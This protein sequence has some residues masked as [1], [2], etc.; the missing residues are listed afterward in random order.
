[1]KKI[2]LALLLI[3][4]VFTLAAC[5]TEPETNEDLV[6]VEE[7]RDALLI[8]GLDRVT[9]DL[10]LPT[11]GR[12]ETTVTWSS[13][14]TDVIGNDGTVTRPAEGEDNATVT[15]TATVT[16]N[17][18]S[19][20]RSFEALVVAFEPSNLFTD[21]TELYDESAINDLVT[22]EGLVSTVFD[23][24]FFV[25]DGAEYV[26]V[27]MGSG[28][29]GGGV[30]EIGDEVAVT[31]LYARYYTLYQLSE[32]ENVEVLST[33]NTVD[34]TGDESTI[35]AVNALDSQ[36]PLIH[37]DFYELTGT[38]V[39][40]GEFNNLFL[41]SDE[42]DDEV[43]IY[44]YSDEDSLTALEE[45]LGRTITVSLAYYT[46]HASN[47]IMMSYYGDGSDV[48]VA[49]LSDAQKLALDIEVLEET[50]F[51][52][53]GDA[54]TLPTT[55]ANGTAYTNWE[56]EDLTLIASDGS[57]VAAPT[58]PTDV[59]FTATA[60]LGDETDTVE[61]TVSSLAVIS[62]EDALDV[63][64]GGY[65]MFTGKVVEVISGN[66][67]FYVYD[68]TGLIYVRDTDFYD[69]NKDDIEIGDSWTFVG[70]RTD[71][72]GL[73]QVASLSL[74]ETSTET[75]EDD[76][77][78]GFTTL[79]SIIAGDIVPGAKYTI[80]GTVEVVVGTYT[81]I[82]VVDGDAR[83]Q[84]HFN[85]N[86]SVIED[87]DGE[88]VVIEIRP[89]QFDY[90]PS[91]V[92]FIGTADDVQEGI[93][94]AQ[95]NELA[96]TA[97]DLGLVT[98]TENVTLPA[99]GKFDLALTWS[100]SNTDVFS[101]TGEVSKAATPQDIVLTLTVGT[102]TDAY[103][104]DYDLSVG[105]NVKDALALEDGVMVYV[106]GTVV[107]LD[108][109][110]DGFFMQDAS[111]GSAIYVGNFDEDIREDV[112]VGDL[113]WILGERDSYTSYGNAQQ[114][115]QN[116]EVLEVVSSDNDIYVFEDMT[117]DEI[118]SGFPGTE[119][120]RFVGVEVTVDSYDTYDHVFFETELGG[121]KLTLD[122]TEVTGWTAEA[123]PV[124]TVL[125]LDF[126]TQ[127]I[128]YNNYRVVDV[129]VNPAE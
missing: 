39:Q 19:A 30:V 13:S 126:T 6:L 33:G 8:S 50:I 89:F 95:K 70:A 72:R 52:T 20:T 49:E 87:F 54:L 24:G 84:I 108:D 92:T 40:K 68:E 128:H 56:S 10:T 23:G 83:V 73:P 7:A 102:G 75:F 11:A 57:Y 41:E 97:I 9:S 63:D 100:S 59:T 47:G 77:N 34:I 36:D 93:T 26:G 45:Y 85:S 94:D 80:Y 101:N 21:F 37:G 69:D 16:L 91:Y 86:A 60:T 110:T 129:V 123:Y 27:Y 53:A 90:T 119:S 104:I 116:A 98:F 64:P 125:V 111:D 38:L 51:Y 2:F 43:L 4:G 66:S 105:V 113:V 79:E 32:V 28:G 25:F 58:E 62:I 82:F 122:I 3:A 103:S 106:L 14:D 117:G 120:Q 15:L 31:G 78:L 65:V 71:Y 17:E 121:M 107:S 88:E 5:N 1:M 109:H 76:E 35:E 67:G 18:E 74:Y 127:R 42:S 29:T 48:V 22:V 124:G 114:Q 61:I 96:A 12:N 46:D 44:Y 118:I 115:V 55:G 112:E 81:D 99:V